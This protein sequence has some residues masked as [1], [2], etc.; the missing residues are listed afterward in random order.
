MLWVGG[1]GRTLFR[2]QGALPLSMRIAKPACGRLV[3]CAE[4]QR[5]VLIFE[6]SIASTSIFVLQATKSQRW[7]P[8][9]LKPKK[10]VGGCDKPRG[11]AY[12]AL[13]RGCPNGETHHSL[14]CGTP[15]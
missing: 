6:N 3:A 1:A 9:R 12:Q 8:W 15:V 14:F 10:D 11:A 4:Y 5:S 13:T 2:L 7:M